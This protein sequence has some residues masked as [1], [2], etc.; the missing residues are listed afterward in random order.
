MKKEEKKATAD[1]ALY[2]AHVEYW[3][4]KLGLKRFVQPTIW[5]EYLNSTGRFY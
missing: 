3:D 2:K 5:H 1:L 4:D